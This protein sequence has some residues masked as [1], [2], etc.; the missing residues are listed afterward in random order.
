MHIVGPYINSQCSFSLSLF[1]C[2]SAYVAFHSQPP[3]YYYF[4][5]R[6]MELLEHFLFIISVAFN[7]G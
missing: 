2:L 4:Q 1:L 3:F 6:N 7:S 5:L